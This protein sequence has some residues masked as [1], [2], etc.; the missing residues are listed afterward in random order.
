MTTRRGQGRVSR[1]PGARFEPTTIAGRR[2]RV[3]RGQPTLVDEVEVVVVDVEDHHD[4]A[5]RREQP[6]A[7]RLAVVGD[8]HG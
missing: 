6:G 3:E 4:V 1:V 2:R 5:R 8:R 7:Q